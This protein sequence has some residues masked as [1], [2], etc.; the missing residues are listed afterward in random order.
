MGP[1]QVQETVPG[2]IGTNAITSEQK[3]K[4][5]SDVAP[6]WVATQYPSTQLA[7]LRIHSKGRRFRF[8]SNVIPP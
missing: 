3:R 5:K 6:E 7:N 8:R 1:A 4:M 2:A